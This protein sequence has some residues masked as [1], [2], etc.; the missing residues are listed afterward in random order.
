MPSLGGCH[1]PPP[2]TPSQTSLAE[3]FTAL[4]IVCAQ[5]L[6]TPLAQI[7]TYRNQDGGEGEG[8]RGSEKVRERERERERFSLSD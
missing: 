5:K 7:L 1:T 2:C 3:T 6:A 8:G 4:S